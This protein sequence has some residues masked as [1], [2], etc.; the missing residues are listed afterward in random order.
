MTAEQSKNTV[1]TSGKLDHAT[2]FW[3]RLMF[4]NR[5]AAGPSETRQN[6]QKAEIISSSKHPILKVSPLIH[7]TTAQVWEFVH[8]NDIP[9]NPLFKPDADGHYYESLGCMT[10]TTRIR[11][12]NL[13]AL[14]DG[15]GKTQQILKKTTK[16][17]GYTTLFDI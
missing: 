15:V 10:C 13:N 12:V 14:D 9:I 16:S 3:K 8:E 11:R 5:H 7:W 2:T 4:D 6:F 1:V 17:V